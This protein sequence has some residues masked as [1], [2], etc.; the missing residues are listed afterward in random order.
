[1]RG[2]S[3]VGGEERDLAEVAPVVRREQLG[4]RVVRA[5]AGREQFE[6]ARAV[7]LLGERLR[8]DRADARLRVGADADAEGPRLHGHP[9]LPGRGVSGDDR[10]GHEAESTLVM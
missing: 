8:G 1:V 10:V 7:A 6:P 5:R 2:G 9:E 4:E 3:P